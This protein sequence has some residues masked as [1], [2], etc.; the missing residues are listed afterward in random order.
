MKSCEGVGCVSC[1][2]ICNNV[3]IR[4]IRDL[5]PDIKVEWKAW[6]FSPLHRNQPQGSWHSFLWSS[7]ALPRLYRELC[8]CRVTEAL[9]TLL[10]SHLITSHLLQ[11]HYSHSIRLGEG[12]AACSSSNVHC[13]GSQTRGTWQVRGNC[14]FPHCKAATVKEGMKLVSLNM[15]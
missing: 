8:F 10:C 4:D 6:G 9:G 13:H 12:K 7:C 14:I 3:K 15:H 5:P 11:N 2:V 1:S